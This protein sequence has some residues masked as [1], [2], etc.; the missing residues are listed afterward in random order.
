MS[1][2]LSYLRNDKGGAVEYVLV[3]AA[4][5]GAVFAAASS[6]TVKTSINGMFTSVFDGAKTKAVMK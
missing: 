6:T 5:G 1:Q 2:F 3:V 4:I